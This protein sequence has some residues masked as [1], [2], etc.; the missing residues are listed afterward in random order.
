L[1]FF[2]F[3]A[4]FARYCT[5]KIIVFS[6]SAIQPQ[7][8]NKLSSVQFNHQWFFAAIDWIFPLHSPVDL[9]RPL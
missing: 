7:V 1:L 3:T 2:L 9:L 5:F 4:L 6:Y 8:C